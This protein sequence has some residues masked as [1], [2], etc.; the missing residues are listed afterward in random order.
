MQAVIGNDGN[1]TIRNV[2]LYD[3]DHAWIGGRGGGMAPRNDD[4]AARRAVDNN[5]SP[6]SSEQAA[7]ALHLRNVHK[8]AAC[9]RSS[10]L[11]QARHVGANVHI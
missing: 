8:T 1:S 6:V 7:Y 3:P 2:R 5:G 9:A 4:A 11:L 10:A